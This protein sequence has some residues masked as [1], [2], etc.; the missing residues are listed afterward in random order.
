MKNLRSTCEVHSP[1]APAH[2][3]FRPSQSTVTYFPS[4]HILLPHHITKNLFTTVSCM[5]T[6]FLAIKSKFQLILKG[7]KTQPEET[8][9]V[10]EPH[11]AETLE[12]IRLGILNNYD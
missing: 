11:M 4:P 12:L 9:Q 7:K 2:K 3:R 6:S 5:D 8:E 1:E 10:S